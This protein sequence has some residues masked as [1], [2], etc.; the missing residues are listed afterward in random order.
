MVRDPRASFG[1]GRRFADLG[2]YGSIY[3]V[4]ARGLVALVRI[5][6]SREGACLIRLQLVGPLCCR[7]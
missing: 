4:C 5:A 1:S 3:K 2:V 7:H 6:S